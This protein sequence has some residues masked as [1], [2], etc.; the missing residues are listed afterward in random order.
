ML[1]PPAPIGHRIRRK[2][3]G[4]AGKCGGA[5]PRTPRTDTSPISVPQL[6]EAVD[7]SQRTLEYVFREGLGITPLQF[8]RRCRLNRALRD[9]RSAAPD[10]RTVT[11]VALKWGFGGLGHIWPPSSRKVWAAS[12]TASNTLV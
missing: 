5:Q 4:D 11:E 7:V 8:M 12:R 1:W 3:G 10:S 6:A 9:L 2:I